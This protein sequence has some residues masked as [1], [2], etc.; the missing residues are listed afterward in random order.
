MITILYANEH[1]YHVKL[2]EIG[3]LK[4]ILSTGVFNLR[5]HKSED[6]YEI[7]CWDQITQQWADIEKM[8][9]DYQWTYETVRQIWTAWALYRKN[10]LAGVILPEWHYR[11]NSDHGIYWHLTVSLSHAVYHPLPT[12]AVQF[13]EFIRAIAVG[14]KVTT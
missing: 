3:D 10:D 1:S 7:V 2:S 4:R 9:A 13:I 5:V 12:P 11:P 8:E 6:I 14:E